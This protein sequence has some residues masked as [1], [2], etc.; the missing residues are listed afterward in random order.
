MNQQGREAAIKRLELVSDTSAAVPAIAE[1]TSLARPKGRTV[2]LDSHAF[3]ETKPL[4]ARLS[5]AQRLLRDGDSIALVEGEKG[6]GKTAFIRQLLANAPPELKTLRIEARHAMGERQ[7]L[8]RIAQALGLG[9]EVNAASLA[10]GL[11]AT[12][13]RLWVA[14]DEAHN[15]SPFAIHALLAV[16]TSLAHSGGRLSLLLAGEPMRL[17]SMLALPSFMTYAKGWITVFQLPRLTEQ[18]TAEFVRQRCEKA[19]FANALDGKQLKAVHRRSRGLPGRTKQ[20]VDELLSGPPNAHPVAMRLLGTPSLRLLAIASVVGLAVLAIGFLIN[21]VFSS[22]PP[23]VTLSEITPAVDSGSP[24]ETPAPMV[25]EEVTIAPPDDPVVAKDE[26][27]KVEAIGTTAAPS[28]IA[29]DPVAPAGAQTS[30]P[31]SSP[32]TTDEA[33]SA[34]L[35]WLLAQQPN[36]YTIQLLNSPDRARAMAFMK[37]RPLSGK[38]VAIETARA[39]GTRYLVLHES[40]SDLAEVQRAIEEL[41]AEL[42]RNDPFPRRI[43]AVQAIAIRP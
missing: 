3:F 4:R 14:I 16:R 36:A 34:D 20:A 21:G 39:A 30:Q 37:Q 43:R 22:P 31:P 25:A 8:D 10:A 7:V 26:A 41:P 27:V 13:P 12:N 38:T 19:G 40:Y 1:G 29:P 5:A 35:T 18:E 17:H 32:A 24:P 9:G 11:A 2:S 15:L 6:A 23:A 28:V 42:R 33:I